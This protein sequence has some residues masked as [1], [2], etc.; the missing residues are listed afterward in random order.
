MVN[1]NEVQ[2]NNPTTGDALYKMVQT[3]GWYGHYGDDDFPAYAMNPPQAVYD[4][5][6]QVMGK[7]KRTLPRYV[8]EY[9]MFPLDAA[10]AGHWGNGSSE[11]RSQYVKHKT[12]ITQNSSRGLDAKY[13]F[14]KFFGDKG[15]GDVSGYYE[16]Y[17]QKYKD[18]D[19]RPDGVTPEAGGSGIGTSHLADPKVLH[20]IAIL[21]A[22]GDTSANAVRVRNYK[23]T[24]ATQSARAITRAQRREERSQAYQQALDLQNQRKAGGRGAY[25]NT[26]NYT[27]TTGYN[28]VSSITEIM[29]RADAAKSSGNDT[30]LLRCMLEILAIIAENTG[31]SASG[32][33]QATELL[34]NLKTGTN[35]VV[36]GNGGST[37]TVQTLKSEGSKPTRNA[38]LAKKI[39]AGK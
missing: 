16:Q 13:T 22:Q 26:D 7:G 27:S 21:R 12:L 39:A 2:M 11:D 8:T 14:Y 25:V 19:P 10:I 31:K 24:K 15:N 30:E 3:S 20:K 33:S 37:G 36:T 1:L 18:E 5:I 35:V 23:P 29:S 9:D 17:Y 34:A 4:A 28:S 32:L 38:Q 6:D